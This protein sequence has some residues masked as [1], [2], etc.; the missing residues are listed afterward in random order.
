MH[1]DMFFMIGKILLYYTW[2]FLGVI[3]FLHFSSG[4]VLRINCVVSHSLSLKGISALNR[5]V[6]WG[7][8]PQHSTLSP[9]SVSGSLF[10]HNTEVNDLK[11]SL[12]LH[13]IAEALKLS[14]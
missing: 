10:Q 5:A 1:I 7:D 13:F 12:I 14:N 4:N 8:F 11:N 3:C 6:A 9:P 2:S